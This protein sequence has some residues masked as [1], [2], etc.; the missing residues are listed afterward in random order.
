MK[1]GFKKILLILVLC[2]LPL[3]L[4]AC[5]KDPGTNN[6]GDNPGTN[7]PGDNPGTPVQ[8]ED[9]SPIVLKVTGKTIYVAPNGKR[10]NPGTYDSPK[11]AYSIYEL[12][13]GDTMIM[14]NGTYEL[15]PIRI[16]KTQSGNFSSYIT[17]RAE[18]T[19]QVVLDFSKTTFNGSNRGVQID[20]DYWYFYGINIKGA[21]DNGMYIGGSYN[22][23][24]MCMFYQNRDTGLQ[25][26]RSEGS[27]T[28]I[29]DWP[30]NNLIKNCTS[31]DNYDDETYG[32]NADGFAAKLT[33]GEGNVFDGCIAYRN[34]DDG[35][36][37]YAKADS[38]NVGITIIKNCIAFENGMTLTPHLADW[39]DPYS[40]MV[41]TTR[42][43][44]GIG[45]KL[46]GEKMEGS[47]YIE[48]CIAF[49][50]KLHGFSDNSNPG[51]I[52][53]VN[54]TAY[55]NSVM[56][57]PDGTIGLSD[58]LSD[59]FDMARQ[60][61]KGTNSNAYHNYYGLLSYSTNMRAPG[62]VYN[63]GDMFKGSVGYSIFLRYSP[64][65]NAPKY[66]QFTTY[67]DGN[68][69][70]SDKA[71]IECGDLTDDIFASVVHNWYASGNGFDLHQ[72][73]RNPDG[74]INT[75]DMLD[76]IDEYY[77]TFCEGK[78]IGADLNK[79][80]WEE[81]DH[82]EF[83]MPEVDQTTQNQVRVLGAYDVLHVMCNPN[84]VFQ[85]VKLLT[86]VNECKVT[87]KSSD[88]SVLKIGTE[89]TNSLSGLSYVIG[90]VIRDRDR[91]RNVTLTATIAYGGA[92]M[93]K[94]FNLRVMKDY[95]AIGNI[96]GLNDKYIIEQYGVWE[97]PDVTITNRASQSGLLLTEGLDYVIT[98][99]YK[100][101]P[102]KNDT[103]YEVSDVYTS[104]PGVYEV[105]YNV[106]S[107]IN[108]QDKV[109][110][111]FYVFVSSNTAIIDLDTV[112]GGISFNVSST[113]VD[114]R[115]ALTSTSGNMYV[116]LTDSAFATAAQIKSNGVAYPVNDDYIQVTVPNDNT[117][118]Y[119]LFVVFVNKANTYTSTPYSAKIE[120]KNISTP[121]EFYQMATSKSSTTT[122]YNITNDIDF[123]NFNWV[124]K[125]HTE[126]FGGY[127]N[128]NGYTI[129]NITL[130]GNSARNVNLFYKI[131]GGTITDLNFEN[132]TLIGDDNN[133]S[134][135]GIIGQMAN[136]YL[137]NIKLRNITA[138][139]LESVAALVGHVSG[140]TNYINHVS[141]VND[142]N[143]TI[144]VT[145]RYCGGIVGN[146]QQDTSE[147]KVELYVDNCLVDAVIGSEIDTG[148]YSGGIVGRYKNELETYL[149][150]IDH[151]VVYGKIMT[152][153]NYAGGI[154]GGCE[155][156]FGTTIISHCLSQIELFYA[157]TYIDGVTAKSVKN[158]SPIFGR[159]TPGSG[160]YEFYNNFGNF[161]DYNAGV[162]DGEELDFKIGRRFF[163]E[164]SLDLDLENIWVLDEVAKRV[165]MKH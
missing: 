68:S 130:T 109:T 115:A 113:G 5:D 21:G 70:E 39:R 53:M 40:G 30:H 8:E 52:T 127:I 99:T 108:P 43:G 119:Y 85:D 146:L 101:A 71:G 110:T 150:V 4:I 82:F 121:Q 140:G 45:F 3:V 65:A 153:K 139:G 15:V 66:Y 135:V 63:N 55:N 32:E 9:K 165:T 147:D 29:K 59:N 94:Q 1:L 134:K 20:A 50:N 80:S 28:N 102:T 98:Y 114:I 88:E 11:D 34:S 90:Q 12:R 77:L 104:V 24:E 2:L 51:V 22:I 133:T 78:Q 74:S 149:L 25:L 86:V 138:H 49:G 131:S 128:G 118:G 26:G 116:Y 36:D 17:V 57:N 157:G 61:T 96:M 72:K 16:P 19:N 145:K 6:P 38:G 158:G 129:S 76:I 35:W 60:N 136:G 31:F 37:T 41:Y 126:T 7:N 23:I 10:E 54:C 105:T 92:V 117:K 152:G 103:F 132:I 73:L 62:V 155:S 64:I 84:A 154:T 14:K 111:S 106:D 100:Y 123:S 58:G 141:L 120:L 95:P 125:E 47:V 143:H 162:S 44:D 107:L 89:T 75:G 69:Y 151:C 163:W 18:T 83:T 159:L 48:N 144:T 42:D 164:I 137:N 124:H 13:A 148:G 122:I 81:Y 97:N 142:A 87:W 67:M 161:A 156:G 27:Y 56:T 112:R 79:S 91:D 46:G 33:V 93:E 160:S